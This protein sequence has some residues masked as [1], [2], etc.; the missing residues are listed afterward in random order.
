MQSGV[1]AQ[2]NQVSTI[3]DGSKKQLI[4]PLRNIQS[5]YIDNTTKLPQIEYSDSYFAEVSDKIVF[6]RL[7]K[8][9][10]SVEILIDSND[11]NKIYSAIQWSKNENKLK[12]TDT[13][14]SIVKEIAAKYSADFVVIPGYCF[15]KYKTIHQKSW[16]D[17]RAG[18]SYERP[19]SITAFVE[20]NIQFFQKDGLLN[21]EGNGKAKSE[22]PLLYSL[23]KKKKFE[24]KIV[25]NSRK[26]YAPPLLKA[27]SK[28]IDNALNNL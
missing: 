16:R 1:S 11:I 22:K 25:E 9:F 13:F 26:V 21:R 20:Y 2:N 19:V 12:F 7:S 27:L 6:Q 10:K 17:A 4:V 3:L 18:S 24:N 14:Q 23:L 28:S 5:D 15:L 8:S